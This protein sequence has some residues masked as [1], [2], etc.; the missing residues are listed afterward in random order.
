MLSEKYWDKLSQ[1]T[2]NKLK[3][4]MYRAVDLIEMFFPDP[5]DPSKRI[6]L[7]PYQRDFIDIIQFGYS[8]SK[9]KYGEIIE[10]PKG[11]IYITRRQVGKSVCCGYTSAALMIL[12]PTNLGRPPCFN[13]IV[14]ASEEEGQLLIDKT[15]YCFE[16]SEFND[17]IAGKVRVDKIKLINKSY[18]KAHTCSH[19]S[20]RGP[21]Y[22]YV[23][24][25]ESAQMDENILFSAAIPTVTHGERWIAITTPQGSKGM[26]INHYI[27]SV[28]T[29]PVICRDCGRNYSQK[30]FLNMNFPVKN[31]IWEMPTLPPCQS[32]GS[33]SYKYGIGLF[34]TP[35]LDPWI[36][37]IIDH[38][39]LRK[40]LDAFGWS[41][42]ARQ[43]LLGEI[44]DEASMVILKEWI[45]NVTN[46]RLRNKMTKD[47]NRFYVLGM[48]YGRLHDAASMCITSRN[49][50]TNR[51]ALDYMDTLAGEFD[52]DTDYDKIHDRLGK[53]I[54]FFKPSLLVMDSTGL[55]Y[56]Q[57]ER[58]QKDLRFKWGVNCKIYCNVKDRLGFIFSSKS[59]MDLIG[60]LIALLSQ[61]E[62]LALEI[63]P[64]SEPEIDKLITELL[65]FECE[66]MDAGYIKYGTQAY[67]DDRVIAYALSL[68]GHTKNKFYTV[69]P[70]GFNYNVLAKKTPKVKF[71]RKKP[72]L[73]NY[74]Y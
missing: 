59:K 67:H 19:K 6:V 36:T 66:I 51:I 28:E 70:K 72:Q 25:D 3:K 55:G 4:S 61:V 31:Q 35:Y 16:E 74:D 18:T 49:P 23:F 12:G 8:L 32:C 9:F 43:E 41:P 10:T 29:R 53:V 44:I 37:P 14:A 65:R 27:K 33:T 24:I 21:A 13:G 42:W 58:V 60:N 71:Y 5:K 69:K 73:I 57:V 50:K 26:L 7:G 62:P 22:H 20:I 38:V 45:D 30:Y 63:P 68:Y 46:P 39:Q 64:R 34:A 48:D 1:S 15:K 40:E 47:K 17:F 54:K 52:F 2:L 11:V 56:S